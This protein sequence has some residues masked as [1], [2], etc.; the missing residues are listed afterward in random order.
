MEYNYACRVIG[1]K[2]EITTKELN[3]LFKQLVKLHH[4]DNGGSEEK[5]KEINAAYSLLKENS[6]DNIVKPPIAVRGTGNVRYTK[7]KTSSE[8]VITYEKALNSDK[9]VLSKLNKYSIECQCVV[10]YQD[11]STSSMTMTLSAVGTNGL[12]YGKINLDRPFTKLSLMGRDLSTSSDE[13]RI[14]DNILG[15]CVIGVGKLW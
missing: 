1:V 9:E 11:G 5:M 15:T 10:Y 14:K 7:P 8:N 13:I 2:S 12:R 6:R 3:R 4:P